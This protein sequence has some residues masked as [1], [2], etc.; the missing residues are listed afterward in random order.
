[1]KIGQLVT[2][3]VYRISPASSND[4]GSAPSFLLSLHLGG[5][6]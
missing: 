5:L 6:A 1:M 2:R 4:D 3:S